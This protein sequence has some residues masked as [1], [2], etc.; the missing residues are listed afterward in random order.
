VGT[1]EE[2]IGVLCDGP[3]TDLCKEGIYIGVPQGLS[4]NQVCN[5]NTGNN[6]DMCNGQDDDCNSATPDGYHE[7]WLSLPCDGPDLDLCEE[8]VFQCV[9][10]LQHC[11]DGTGSNLDV[12]DGEDNDC[13]PSTPDGAHEV[14]FGLTCDGP[15]LDECEDGHW[16]CIGVGGMMCDDDMQSSVERCGGGDEDCDGLIDEDDGSGFLCPLVPNHNSLGTEC[17]DGTC[18]LLGCSSGYFDGDGYPSNGCECAPDLQWEGG[19]Q[20]NGS[21]LVAQNWGSLHDNQG[22][23]SIIVGNILTSA[24][25]D[26]HM[27]R[28][29]DE[30]EVAPNWCDKFDVRVQFLENPN[31]QFAFEVRVGGDC[32]P[33]SQKCSDADSYRMTTSFYIAG[34]E[35]GFAGGECPC[36]PYQEPNEKLTCSTHDDCNVDSCY[37]Y[38][39]DSGPPALPR[40]EYLCLMGACER[41]CS[42]RVSGFCTSG[43]CAELKPKYPVPNIESHWVCTNEHL[44][45]WA[46]GAPNRHYCADQT[47]NYHIRVY[48]RDGFPVTCDNY[49]LKIS[50]GIQ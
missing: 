34:T 5:D 31:N 3:D 40:C 36:S 25:S 12:C 11:N 32:S 38:R 21:C 16:V 26:W 48:R 33:E 46:K 13:D 37:P 39:E 22:D 47:N 17:V 30:G 14:L 20:I 2:W 9:G 42:G 29:V 18:R 49:K 28:A 1:L 8:G 15:D 7:T 10:G 44:K 24:E 45:V 43:L 41:E 23:S 27:F 35:G 19:A 6:L 4:C 50:N